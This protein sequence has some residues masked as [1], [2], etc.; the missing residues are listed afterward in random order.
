MGRIRT[1]LGVQTNEQAVAYL[2]W[3]H[4]KVLAG[5]M[6]KHGTLQALDWHDEHEI[7]LC[8]MCQ[9]LTDIRAARVKMPGKR[10]GPKRGTTYQRLKPVD[11]LV[12][13]GAPMEHG[14]IEMARRHIRSKD[15]I[16]DL[17]CGCREA[18]QEWWRE[19]Q[20]ARNAS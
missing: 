11:S 9:A 7:P 6:I 2:A 14:T 13:S 4:P 8:R 17:T 5:C 1:K 19:Y 10:P 3:Y 16:N 18:Y 20:R 12:P 15:R